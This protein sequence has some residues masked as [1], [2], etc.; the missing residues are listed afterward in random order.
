MDEVIPLMIGTAGHVDHGKT[1]LLQRL[2]GDAPHA[3]RLPEERER[4]LTIDIG[5]A[6]LSLGDGRQVGVVDVPG[7]EK[8]VRNMVAAASGIDVILLVVAADDGVMPQTREHLEIADLLGAGTGVVALTKVDLVDEDLAEAAEEE[9]R[10]LIVGTFLEDA[11][12]IHVS[13]VTG[14]GIDELRAALLAALDRATPRAADGI[15]RVPVQRSF[16]LEGHGTVITGVPLAGRV[17]LGQTLEVIP[18]RRKCRVRAIQA[19]HKEVSEGRAGHRTALKLSDVSLKEVRR[20]DVVAEPGF[21]REGNLV[22]ARLKFLPTRPRKL[23]SNF[24]V[25]FHTGTTEVVGRV[26]LLDARSLVPGDEALVQFR[27]DRPIVTAPGDRFVLR[28]PS[29]QITLGGGRVIGY[30]RGKLS[31]GK[32]RQ[33]KLVRAREEGLDDLEKAILYHVRASGLNPLGRRDLAI[34]TLRRPEEIEPLVADLVSRGVLVAVND[35]ALHVKELDRGREKLL[36]LL[37][38]FHQKD[39]LVPAAGRAWAREQLKIGEAA[40]DAIQTAEDGV[41]VVAAGRIRLTGY[42]PSLSPRQRGRVERIE[43]LLLEERFTPPRETDLPDLIGAR[44]DEAGRLLDL[45]IEEGKV[46]R[47]G[48]G[49]VLHAKAVEEAKRAVTERIR[50]NGALV[51]SDLKELLGMSRKY[52]IPLLEWLDAVRFTVRKGDNRILA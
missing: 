39:P 10:E 1:T 22:E 48:S 8:F 19:Y 37:G 49:V 11:P 18:G 21:L 31:E 51:P 32:S 17:I 2:V 24:P 44:A 12:V 41:E 30:S 20:G 28:T 27:L 23:T 40:F 36:D 16:M 15:F 6:E 13:S 14:A 25:R 7:H 46:V 42:V 33:V 5:Y 35:R 9:V 4:G 45:L 26:F 34:E 3:D 52:S 47:I 43:E 38:R 50:A 29:P